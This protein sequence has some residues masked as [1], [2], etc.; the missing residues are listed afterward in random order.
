[1]AR[2]AILPIAFGVA[3][4]AALALP[5]MSLGRAA[6]PRLAA[7]V[8]LFGICGAA[9]ALAT[10]ALMRRMA[11]SPFTARY[12]A[13][14]VA[15]LLGTAGLMCSVMTVGAAG[16][17]LFEGLPPK[18]IGLIFAYTVAA[19]LYNFLAVAGW[20]LLPLGLPVIVIFAGLL[21]APVEDSPGALTSRRERS[22]GT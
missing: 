22:T 9:A 18:T 16:E 15:L 13:A 3:M 17:H 6:T 8:L 11:R 10:S 7:A 21:A 14:L 12:A 4:A 2:R 1:V 5:W 19:S 20:L